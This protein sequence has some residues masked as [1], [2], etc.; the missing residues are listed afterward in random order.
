MC[1]AGKKIRYT[2][3]VSLGYGDREIRKVAYLPCDWAMM[4][5]K[6]AASIEREY[7][8]DRDKFW[9]VFV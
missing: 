1:D 2:D 6:D 5:D 8:Q 7:A 4:K 3:K 9:K